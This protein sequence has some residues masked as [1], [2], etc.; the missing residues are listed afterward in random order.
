MSLAQAFAL[1]VDPSAPTKAEEF[2]QD[3]NVRLTCPD[4]G[5]AGQVIEEFSSGDLVCGNCGLVL[6][7]KVVDTRSEWRTFADSDGDDPS[8]VGGPADPLLDST[9]Q[10]S[11]V[12]SFKDN[13]TGVARALQMAASRVA[14]DAQGGSGRDLQGAFREIATM[15]EAIS[16]PKAIIDTSKMLFKRVDEEKALRGKSEAAIIAACIFIAC[17]QGRV[18]RTF[19]EIVALTNVSKKEIAGA[20]KQ[21]DKLFDT[22]SPHGASSTDL[23]SLISRI[24]NHLALPVPLQRACS[25]CGQKTVDDGVL[26]GRNPITIAS[27][28]ILFVSTLWGRRVDPKEIAKVGGV[29]DST[30]RT[31]YR[32]LLTVKERLVDSRW[33][34][35]SRPADQRADWAN[36]TG[37]SSS[38]AAAS[39]VGEDDD[40]A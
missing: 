4:C 6:G 11:T 25:L 23:D 8:R 19:K 20:F 24:C 10:L 36:I 22:S 27:S 12:I 34:D 21:I 29:Q 5:D 38:S 13:N 9:D 31:G 17:R 2:R 40:Y 16:L 35:A 28:C 15:C 1:K 37:R 18:P 30:I 32:L 7:D 14:K 26:A 39:A 33:F 3:L